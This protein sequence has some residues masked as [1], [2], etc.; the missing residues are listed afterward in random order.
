MA[1]KNYNAEAGAGTR[2]NVEMED[3]AGRE[4]REKL[5]RFR[6]PVYALFVFC[7]HARENLGR[8]SIGC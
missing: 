1:L 2:K 7:R 4:N 3:G 6:K 5:D 8:R